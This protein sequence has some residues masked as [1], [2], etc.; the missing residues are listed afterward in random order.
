MPVPYHQQGAGPIHH[1]SGSG[2]P[3]LKF[4]LN[5]CVQVTRSSKVEDPCV[6]K[7]RGLQMAGWESPGWSRAHLVTCWT[8]TILSFLH[9]S[10]ETLPRGSAFRDGLDRPGE[11][12]PLLQKLGQPVFLRDPLNIPKTGAHFPKKKLFQT[13]QPPR[14]SF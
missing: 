11:A 4:H 6:I 7:A 9:N 3:P 1:S 2:E 8:F 13:I 5:Q 14:K 12:A 10:P